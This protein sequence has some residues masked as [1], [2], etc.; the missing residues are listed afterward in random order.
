MWALWSWSPWQRRFQQPRFL[1][2]RLPWELALLQARGGGEG[3]H[4]GQGG[5]EGSQQLLPQMAPWVI[6][7][8]GSFSA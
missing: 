4:V 8:V 3:V 7:C 2:W 6:L 1:L 5:F